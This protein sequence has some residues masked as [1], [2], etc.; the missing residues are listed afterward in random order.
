M[1]RWTLRLIP[2]V[3]LLLGA[4]LVS[5]RVRGSRAVNARLSELLAR[6][7]KLKISELEPSHPAPATNAAVALLAM[8]NQITQVASNWGQLLPAGRFVTN[9]R[10][11]VV[12]QMAEWTS[13]RVTNSWLK[14]GPAI[15][16]ERATLAAMT[17]ALQQSAW[18]DGFKYRNGFIDF[19]TP[20]VASFKQAA[21]LLNA[22]ALWEIRNGRLE[23]A[24]ERLTTL[25]RLVRH[26]KDSPLIITQLVRISCAALAWSG[27]WEALQSPGWNDRQ[28]AALQHAWEEMD[29]VADML[30]ATEME[31][32]MSLDLYEQVAGSR[33]KFSKTIAQLT[34]LNDLLGDEFTARLF[35]AGL[36]L[37]IHA[38]V[39][40]FAWLRQDE[41]RSLNRWQSVLELGRMAHAQSWS[42]IRD[43]D[44]ARTVSGPFFSNES[45]ESIRQ[46]GSYD[47]L[48]YLFSNDSFG[49]VHSSVILKAL[50]ID[51]QRRMTVIALAL[52]RHRLRHGKFPAQ[53]GDLVPEFLSSVPLDGMDGQPIRYRTGP[54]GV[55]TLYSVGEDGRDDGGDSA[56]ADPAKPYTHIWNGKDAVWPAPALPLQGPPAKSR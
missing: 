16:K 27:T 3:L 23:Q 5:E 49:V 8:T 32:A 4:F 45:P 36:P 50:T 53:L 19:Q 47:R 12:S 21:K 11:T 6:G 38:H 17:T 37:W 52:E 48:R 46:Q 22:A 25:L 34:E 55:F 20:P 56:G 18:D 29:F 28:L 35:P 10:L 42:A 51:T 13:G 39:W 15:D 30:R 14:L 44:G 24:T 7:E 40:R 26:Q 9:G 54:D 2:V 43:R 41:I 31:R 1:L 33:Q